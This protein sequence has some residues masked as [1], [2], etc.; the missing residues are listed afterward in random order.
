MRDKKILQIL[1]E[2]CRKRFKDGAKEHGQF[3]PLTD[4]RNF[5][6]MLKEELADGVNYSDMFIMIMICQYFK[7]LG[8]REQEYIRTEIS[9]LKALLTECYKIIY[10]LDKFVKYRI[11]RKE[12][13]NEEKELPQL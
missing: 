3:N 6:K 8:E 11:K 12:G 1:D 9:L 7:I 2:H 5:L 13:Q 4:K 10:N